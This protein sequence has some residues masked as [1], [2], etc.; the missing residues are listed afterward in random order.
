MDGAWV[1]P[2]ASTKGEEGMEVFEVRGGYS[3]GESRWRSVFAKR[4]H[5]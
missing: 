4:V 1:L 5:G 2:E 3:E